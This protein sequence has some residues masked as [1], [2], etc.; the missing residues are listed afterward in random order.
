MTLR[1][2]LLIFQEHGEP[3]SQPLQ[4]VGPSLHK[5]A[6]LGAFLYLWMLQIQICSRLQH[7]QRVKA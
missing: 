5:T 1:K 2:A 3:L 4:L 6:L 7:V